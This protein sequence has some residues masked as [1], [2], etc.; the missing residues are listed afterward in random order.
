MADG[1]K[2]AIYRQLSSAPVLTLRRRRWLPCVFIATNF[3]D[4]RIPDEGDFVVFPRP[5]L[6]NLASAQASRRCTRNTFEA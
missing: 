6:E 4:D 2:Y 5:V 1:E 3:F